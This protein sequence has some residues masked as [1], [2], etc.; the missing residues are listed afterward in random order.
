M[1]LEELIKH[2][3]ETDPE[4]FKSELHKS[5]QKHYQ[6]IFS[7]GHK[8]GKGQTM[9]KVESL[10]KQLEE[11]TG[12]LEAKGKELSAKDDEITKISANKPDIEQIKSDYEQKLIAKDEAAAK[13]LKEASEKLE[14]LKKANLDKEK[15]RIRQQLINKVQ[16]LHVDEW[17]ANRAISEDIMN[18]VVV[19]D[20]GEMK[21]YQAD[22]A[23][24][25]TAPEGGNV[26][27]ILAH[28]VVE[29]VPKQ[30]VNP[31][32]NNDSGYKDNGKQGPADLSTKKRSEHS[33]EEKIAFVRENGREAWEALPL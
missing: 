4:A 8:S 33:R 30:Y 6:L 29:S 14:A 5:A 3:G 18:R 25:I 2:I 15:E 12:Q 24:P 16:G 31:P 22:K 19:S 28:E 23:T 26:L 27:D 1:E 11:V 10:E 7:D 32:K 17:A 20:D 9:E 13:S 21:V